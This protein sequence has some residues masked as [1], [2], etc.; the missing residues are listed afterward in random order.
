MEHEQLS[1]Q[2]LGECRFDSPLRVSHFIEDDELVLVDATS[3]HSG[4][5]STLS[6]ENAGPRRRL[7]FDPARTRAAIVTCGGLCPGLNNVIQSVVRMLRLQYGVPSVLG[8]RYGYA[9]LVPD[10]PFPMQEL[11]INDVD[12]IHNQGGTILG[13]SRGH[14]AVERM[15]DTL[16]RREID[17]LFAVGGDGTLRGATLLAEELRRR[18]APIAV[19]AIPKT[20]DNDIAYVS[21]T[22]G[23]S[24]AVTLATQALTGAHAEAKG[25]YNGVVVVKVMGRDSGFIACYSAIASSEVNFCLIP[26]S[27]FRL[28]G[29]G[30]LLDVLRERLA[31][32]QHALIVVAEG[33]GQE[34]FELAGE[35]D[36]SGNIR[37][38]DIGQKL[39]AEIKNYFQQI[40][41][42]IALKY[43]DPS[44]TI[45][46]VPAVPEDAVFCTMLSQNAV[47][48]AMSGRTSFL[49]GFWN[50]YYTYVPLALLQGQRKRVEPDSYLWN[51]V[52]ER[53][54][55]PELV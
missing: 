40:G 41:Q 5:R 29:P 3:S 49:A 39:T 43:I 10:S 22:F 28:F 44:Y 30:G 21:R 16:Q 20:I 52:R 26:E 17:I 7:Y 42:P 35:R 2:R 54:G 53:T 24:T 36:A 9:G 31:R 33:A 45:R 47:H 25:A 11:S 15:A 51:I 48:G 4:P 1:V 37:Y 14:Q 27:K 12:G 34:L 8:V 23:F 32:K 50:N 18:G 13:S 46:S 6:F 55:Q 38:G 19:A